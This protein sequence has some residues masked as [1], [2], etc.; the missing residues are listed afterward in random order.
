MNA[1]LYLAAVCGLWLM[2]P[3]LIASAAAAPALRWQP[4]PPLP[5]PLGFAGAYA[6]V[7]GGA[8]LVAGGANFTSKMPWEGG[9]KSWHHRVFVLETP[10]GPWKPVFELPHECGYGVSV[11]TAEGV[12]C[13]GGS[14][15]RAHAKE[16]F[17][18]SWDGQSVQ[19]K[20]LPPLPLPLANGCGAL[21]GRLIY[22]AGGTDAPDATQA[23]R[24]FLQLDLDH[25]ESGWKPLPPWP[26]RP[27][28]LATAA[29]VD[30]TFYV[31][32]GADLH[33]D[34]N[35]QPVRTYL[36]DAWVYEPNRGW[37]RI[38]DL[39]NTVVAAASP[40]PVSGGGFLVVSG[41]DGSRA[42]FEP[43]SRHPGFDPRVLHYDVKA[44]VWQTVGTTPAPRATLPVVEWRHRPVFISGEV[45]PGVRSPEVWALDTR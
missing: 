12:V 4:L 7:S 43:K 17:R 28:M 18:L 39:P 38:A 8:L 24:T 30:G 3:W 33:P 21:A 16:V 45:R 26:G 35:G 13:I 40:A 6:G 2:N 20:F 34:A 31:V 29:V 41:D 5:D 23:L 9:A 32:G 15:A 14:N 22:V 37:R 10:D 44:D 27:R 42:G 1:H 19:M 25:L 11:T 36:T